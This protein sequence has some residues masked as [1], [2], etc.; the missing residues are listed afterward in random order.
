MAV[1]FGIKVFWVQV[2]IKVLWGLKLIQFWG[3]L[4]K[5]NNTKLDTK[6]NIY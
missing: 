4:F 2:Q 6:V 1:N 3:A 5:K